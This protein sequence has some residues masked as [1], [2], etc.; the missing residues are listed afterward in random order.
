MGTAYLFRSR[1]ANSTR[2]S[3]AHASPAFSVCSPTHTH[4]HLP[5]L[6]APRVLSPAQPDRSPLLC[7]ISCRSFALVIRFAG[8]GWPNLA[9]WLMEEASDAGRPAWIRKALLQSKTFSQTEQ[10]FRQTVEIF[11]NHAKCEMQP[12]S[13]CMFVMAGGKKKETNVFP[14]LKLHLVYQ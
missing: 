10:T 7:R 1:R 11:Q 9:L 12:T 2:P 13:W 3:I 8:P 6:F 14:R 5:L 4:T